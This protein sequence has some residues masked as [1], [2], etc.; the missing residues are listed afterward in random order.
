M[1]RKFHIFVRGLTAD[2][3]AEALRPQS[4]QRIARMI[5]RAKQRA[6]LRGKPLHP[7]RLALGRELLR[8]L[9]R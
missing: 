8:T 7:S 3:Y 1:D 4:R 6:K 5:Y 2:D 9:P